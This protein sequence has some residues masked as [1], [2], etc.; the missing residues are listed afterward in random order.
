MTDSGYDSNTRIIPRRANGYMP[1]PGGLVNAG[2]VH[3]TVPHAAGALYSTTGDLLKWERA[4]L[5]GKLLSAASLQKM[6]TPNKA[7][8]AYGVTVRSPNGRRQIWHNGGIDGFN[9]SMAHYPDSGLTIIVLGNVNGPA[10]DQIVAMLGAIGHG[11]PVQLPTERKEIMLPAAAAAYVG[12]YE[13]APGIT[14]TV[15]QKGGQIFAQ[16]TG[17]PPI[18]IFAE[19][20]TAFFLKAVDAQ[21]T[22]GVEGDAVTHLVLHQNGRD[23]K[24]IRRQP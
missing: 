24:A 20:A 12:A 13:L 16:L 18:E 19:S 11:D 2:F 23:Q 10:P 7:D 14:I 1:G 5:G 6:L 8:Y 9:A 15:T 3:M 17:Q 21:I 4:L 22:F